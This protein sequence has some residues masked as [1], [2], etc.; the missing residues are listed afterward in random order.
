MNE[1]LDLLAPLVL[2]FEAQLMTGVGLFSRLS[3]LMLMLPGIGGRML[4][5]QVRLALALGLMS[6]LFP[7]VSPVESGTTGALVGLIVGEILVGLTLG[8]TVRILL[9]AL[10]ISGAIIAQTL[11]LSQIFGFSAEGDSSSLLSTILTLGA[12]TLFLTADLEI[13]A[14]RLLIGNLEAMPLGFAA[15]LPSSDIAAE[16]TGLAAEAIRFGITLT[17]P[18]L[19]LNFAYYIILG[20]LN[21]AMP[22]LMITFVGLPAVTLGGL[23]LLTLSIVAMLTVWLGRVAGVL[24]S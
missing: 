20:F 19:V 1:I 5:I 21:R 8:F 17:L 22:Q 23:T 24:G 16:A 14:I 2:R 12:S 10:S 3:I 7:L 4:P 18:F 9:F 13:E 15:T 11:S 6:I